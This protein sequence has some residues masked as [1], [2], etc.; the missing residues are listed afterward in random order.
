[1]GGTFQITNQNSITEEIRADGS[2]SMVA[3]IRCRIFY[4]ALCYP[5]I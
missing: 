1:M 3:I 5:K 4:L 2:Q